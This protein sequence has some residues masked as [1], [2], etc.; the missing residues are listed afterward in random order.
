MLASPGHASATPNTPP[1]NAS[2]R[3]S[4]SSICTVRQRLEPSAERIASSRSRA[5]PRASKRL[6]TLTQQISKTNPTAPP[7]SNKYGRMLPTSASRSGLSCSLMPS[8]VLG[9]S[10]ASWAPSAPSS[11]LCLCER[12]AVF[13]T[14]N[15]RM[16]AEVAGFPEIGLVS[17]IARLQWNP[18]DPNVPGKRKPGGITPTIVYVAPRNCTVLPSTSRAPPKLVCHKP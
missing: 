16:H 9:N 12:H 14:R 13:D 5:A 10:R 17:G 2:S 3:L 7:S 11:D 1:T 6:A 8:L 18:D 4:T 15:G